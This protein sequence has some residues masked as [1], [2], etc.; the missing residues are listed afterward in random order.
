MPYEH[1]MDDKRVNETMRILTYDE[2]KTGVSAAIGVPVDDWEKS[3]GKYVED[4]KDAKL[5]FC[6]YTQNVQTLF[7]PADQTGIWA[8]HREGVKGKGKLSPREVGE[9]QAI[10]KQKNLLL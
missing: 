6:W 4:H 2:A 10:A 8:F 3:F 5:I 1:I 7:C 9:L